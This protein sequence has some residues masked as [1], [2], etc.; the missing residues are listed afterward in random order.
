M[1]EFGLTSPL[2]RDVN[3]YNKAVETFRKK[4]DRYNALPLDS[5]GRYSERVEPVPNV[6]RDAEG[7]PII[8][9]PEYRVNGDGSVSHVT[10]VRAPSVS[11]IESTAPKNPL[12]GQSLQSIADA[13]MND[14]LVDAD[15]QAG[16]MIASALGRRTDE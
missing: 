8:S 13:L 5:E 10:K 9:G 3:T 15:R 7:T 16:G 6:P 4:I 12:N 14:T 2:G 1:S 11:E